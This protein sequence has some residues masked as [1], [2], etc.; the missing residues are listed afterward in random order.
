MVL[1]EKSECFVLSFS[2]IFF[3]VTV[4]YFKITDKSTFSNWVPWH[5]ISRHA[6]TSKFSQTLIGPFHD[7]FSWD[8]TK[9]RQKIVE[10]PYAYGL[11]INRLPELRKDYSAKN[12]ASQG[13]KPDKKRDNFDTVIR[14]QKTSITETR[15]RLLTNFF[16]ESN[17]PTFFTGNVLCWNEALAP[18]RWTALT[19][20]FCHQV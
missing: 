19:W 5:T 14:Y 17:F 6:S 4:F 16:F 10:T 2:T 7:R 11:S 12:F 15:K 13:K 3:P 20:K 8:E 1:H 9:F 18:D